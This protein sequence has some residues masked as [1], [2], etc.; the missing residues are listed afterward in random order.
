[1]SEIWPTCWNSELRDETRKALE[2]ELYREVMTG[3]VLFGQAVSA[4]ALGGSGDDVVYQLQ[5]GR[6]A[7][8]H[9]TWH[10]ETSPE[11]PF[12]VTF[13]DFESL[14]KHKEWD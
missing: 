13:N 9:L 5:D 1:M 14:A 12:T 3:H 11:F 7:V 8:V 10:I 4:K 2:A 6:Y